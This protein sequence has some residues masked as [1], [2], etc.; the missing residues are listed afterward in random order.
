MPGVDRTGRTYPLIGASMASP[1]KEYSNE[2]ERLVRDKYG[3]RVMIMVRWR[4]HEVWLD[5]NDRRKAKCLGWSHK[6]AKAWAESAEPIKI[7]QAVGPDSRIALKFIYE[8]KNG[9]PCMDCGGT[10][11]HYAMDFDHVRGEKSFNVGSGV[12]RYSVEA[13]K[14][15]IAKCELVCSNCHRIRH[16]VRRKASDSRSNKCSQD[17]VSN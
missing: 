4:R 15:E 10:F 12:G 1:T 9:V 16:H 8:I 7:E 3:D 13:L 5:F 11:P 14:E 2:D 6:P 17:S